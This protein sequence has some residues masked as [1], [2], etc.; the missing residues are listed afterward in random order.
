[1][2]VM[3]SYIY[4]DAFLSNILKSS[5][6]KE[7]NYIHTMHLS[8]I[9]FNKHPTID[10]IIYDGIESNGAIN[11]A[12]KDSSHNNHLK[13]ESCF[14]FKINKKYGYGIYDHTIINRSNNID[15]FGNI[16]WRDHP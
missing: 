13:P 8:E 10:G 11:I 7:N 16:A 6:A 2:D 9:V 4:T 1:M 14:I 5:E 15:D 12:L 3:R